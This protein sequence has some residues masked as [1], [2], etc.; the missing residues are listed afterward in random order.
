MTYFSKMK[1]LRMKIKKSVKDISEED[2][3]LALNNDIEDCLKKKFKKEIHFR[4]E[5]K[6]NR[7]SRR[8]DSAF[9]NFIIEYKKPTVS[10]G[11][12]ELKQIFDYMDD[13]AQL[14]NND[15]V[16]GIIT[17]GK[18]VKYVEYDKN[19][20]GYNIIDNKSGE[21]TDDKIEDICRELAEI[22]KITLNKRNINDYLGLEN[23][24]R[25]KEIIRLLL[26]RIMMSKLSRTNL[27][28]NEW[29]R[30]TR[31]SSDKDSWNEDKG[32]NKKINDFYKS[33][34][35]RS[36]NNNKMQYK[37]LFVV[38]TY[39]SIIVKLVLYKYLKKKFNE[40]FN[41]FD[42]KKELFEE[43]ILEQ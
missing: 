28:Y 23:S 36:I 14:G 37:C 38:Q 25:I 31:L 18:E 32:K 17:N 10:L 9:G 15:E 41:N 43:N 6:L 2:V 29:E 3:R 20:R 24:E 42:L 8:I 35:N 1:N 19:N 33:L 26:K 21:L 16:W 40:S 13:Y 39:Y 5:K 30:L 34:F 7:N 11:D 22:K 27:L 12:K 4:S